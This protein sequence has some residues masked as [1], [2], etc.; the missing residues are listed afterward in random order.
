M[1]MLFDYFDTNRLA[2]CL[3]PSSLDLL[4]DFFGDRSVTRLL[5]VDC[6][7]SDEYLTG[8]A[9]RI[10]LAGEKTPADTLERILPTIRKDILHESDRIR[11]ADFENHLR[12]REIDE[13]HEYVAPLM[14]FLSISEEAATRIAES[15]HLFAD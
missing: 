14:N 8:H 5:E 1:R 2:I 10:G 15:P 4:H 9:M 6:Y 3:D 11:D 12:L 13:V 7:F